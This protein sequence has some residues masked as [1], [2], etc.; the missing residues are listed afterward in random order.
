MIEPALTVFIGFEGFGGAAGVHIFHLAN[1]IIAQG[2]QAIAVVDGP[3]G[4]V[5]QFGEPLFRILTVRQA[6]AELKAYKGTAILHCWT[7]RVRAARVALRLRS[8]RRDPLVVHFEDDE[9]SIRQM[10][11]ATRPW[12]RRGSTSID[13]TNLTE[14]LMGHAAAATYLSASPRHHIPPRIP[15]HRLRLGFDSNFDDFDTTPDMELRARLQIPEHALVVLYAGT[16]HRMNVGDL[17]CLYD[18]VAISVAK[19]LPVVLLRA[20][21]DNAAIERYYDLSTKSWARHLPDAGP[22]DFPALVRASDMTVLPGRG[23]NF[24]GGRIPSKLPFLLASGTPVITARFNLVPPLKEGVEALVVRES[25]SVELAE[26]IEQVAS[27]PELRRTLG[28]NGRAYALGNFS[29]QR[30]AEE[31]MQFYACRVGD[32]ERS[33]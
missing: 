30:S 24:N 23:N 21:Q 26:A 17:V 22:R 2:R 28:L 29:W 3:P 20:G 4:D 8:V 16:G 14:R 9:E 10:S 11:Y 6:A 5:E 19:G 7:P 15:T 31:L 27:D 32:A 1:A 12:W 25:T 18:A 33:S 13:R